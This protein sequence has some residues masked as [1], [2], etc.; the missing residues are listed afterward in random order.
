MSNY[1]CITVRWL[2]DRYH[3]LLDRDGPPEWPPSPFRLLQALVAGVA[4]HRALDSVEGK[5]LEWLESLAA[6]SIIA[7]RSRPGQVVTH[8]VPNNDGDKEPDRQK[9]L[10]AK[11]FRPT[12]MLDVPEVHYLW[13]ASETGPEALAVIQA[14]RHLSCLGWGVDGAY[15]R[16]RILGAG[17]VDKLMG[18]RWLPK[19]STPREDGLLRVPMP[20]SLADL[21]RAHQTASG[22]VMP[23]NPLRA[24][25]KPRVFDR[26][27]YASADRP[28]SR[29]Y[30]VFA[31]RKADG[32]FFRYA[33]AKLIHIAGMTRNAAIKAMQAY[34]PDNPAIQ[35]AAAWVETFVAGHRPK[36]V[37]NHQQFS[38][39]PVPSIGT[40]HADAAI[41]RVM[42]VAPFGCDGPLAHLATQLDGVEL[43]PEGGGTG[44]ILERLRSDGVTRQYVGTSATWASVTPVIL[45][46]YDDHKP[47]KTER[48]IQ[49]ALRQSGIEQPCVFTWGAIP[50]FNN[51]LAAYKHD[52]NNRPIG[53]FRPDHLQHGTAVHVRVTF[54]HADGSP[55]LVSGPLTV[56]AGR[57]C[58][59]GL[60]AI[61]VS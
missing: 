42:I 15:A 9:R 51:C 23:G 43:T 12:I 45:P 4:R 8:Y 2:D 18:V 47:A 20:G 36:G 25:E 52:R 6:P 11:T 49:K 35:D 57:H 58:G 55:V 30:V 34:P 24:V 53:Y 31:L 19:P 10:T 27:F 17:E 14:A 26:I 1:L 29:P 60:L 22:R 32:D 46:G 3:G 5:A 40:E 61:N 41:R 59:L 39:V 50:N 28:L 21:R 38:Y 16:G 33:H 44:P 54:R 37:T 48:L 56:G 7:P 13:P